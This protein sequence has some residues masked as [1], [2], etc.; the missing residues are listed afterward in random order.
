MEHRVISLETVA[1]KSNRAFDGQVIKYK[2]D[3]TFE[4]EL[5]NINSLNINDG[6]KIRYKIVRALEG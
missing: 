1:T 2:N 5:R 6:H 3:I 4:T